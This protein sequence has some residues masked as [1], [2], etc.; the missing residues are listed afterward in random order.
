MSGSLLM[1]DTDST[2]D[3]ESSDSASP[4]NSR[5]KSSVE[6]AMYHRLIYFPIGQTVCLMTYVSLHFVCFEVYL[7]CSCYAYQLRFIDFGNYTHFHHIGFYALVLLFSDV[8]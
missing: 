3:S 5:S 7:Y 2:S 4:T 6:A 8:M 1:Q